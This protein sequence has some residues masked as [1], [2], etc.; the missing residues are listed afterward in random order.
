MCSKAQ[1][2]R[3]PPLFFYRKFKNALLHEHP[4]CPYPASNAPAEFSGAKSCQSPDPSVSS[5]YGS[6]CQTAANV[7]SS[8]AL[9][10]IGSVSSPPSCWRLRLERGGGGLQTSF[11]TPLG[12]A[13]SEG[14]F[15]S[16]A[17]WLL[18]AGLPV[19]GGTES[20]VGFRHPATC[21]GT[22]FWRFLQRMLM[23]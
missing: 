20:E 16:L 14:W 18:S 8:P 23:F 11:W 9:A 13:S 2:R 10:M 21:D 12:A 7:S 6:V 4:Q 1:H 5:A 3:F 22:R 17:G 15:W 19:A